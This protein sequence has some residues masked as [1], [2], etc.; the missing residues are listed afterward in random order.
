MFNIKY[1]E[2]KEKVM[3]G[4]SFEL[5]LIVDEKII[6]TK[7]AISPREKEKGLSG[8]EK[9]SQNE[10]MLFCYERPTIVSF[11]MREIKFSKL[12]ILFL[13]AEGRVMGKEVMTS[14]TPTLT[15]SSKEP[16]C[17]ALELSPEIVEKIEVGSIV[18]RF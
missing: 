18:Q 12:G 4:K 8:V 16:I 13:D 6:T 11:W 7:V 1:S 9:L 10:G 15:Y 2:I 14:E 3:A 5:A 17:Y